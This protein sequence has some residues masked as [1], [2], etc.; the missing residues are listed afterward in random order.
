MLCSHIQISSRSRKHQTYSRMALDSL[1]FIFSNEKE[2]CIIQNEMK[3]LELSRPCRRNQI[4][5]FKKNIYKFFSHTTTTRQIEVESRCWMWKLI[6]SLTSLSE[7]YF[8]N[9]HSCII[10]AGENGFL[11]FHFISFLPPFEQVKTAK[12][13]QNFFVVFHRAAHS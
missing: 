2:I 13:L 7:T 8:T 5:N 4:S 11:R 9:S 12:I 6:N 1:I 10:W 3:Y